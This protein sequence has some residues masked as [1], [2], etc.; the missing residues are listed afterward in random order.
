MIDQPMRYTVKVRITHRKELENEL[1]R[2]VEGA[3][4]K[5]LKNPG[6]GVLVTRHDRQ[7]FTVELSHEVPHG[8]ISEFDLY[9]SSR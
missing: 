9:P 3:I 6:R 4:R 8:T 2:A 5:A 1:D 7:T